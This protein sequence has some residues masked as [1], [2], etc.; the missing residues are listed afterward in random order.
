[1]NRNI[2]NIFGKKFGKLLVVKLTNER[3]RGYVI[4]KCKCDC[5]NISFVRSVDLL[6]GNVKSCGC[7][8]KEIGKKMIKTNR[9][10]THGHTRNRTATKIYMVWK[11]MK[12]R[13]LNSNN[14]NFKYYGGRGITICERWMKF[15]NFLADM[16]EQPKG[17]TI[18]RID[19]DGNYEPSNC[20]WA[21][22]KEQMQNSRRWGYA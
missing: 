2:K 4:W 13:C 18:E 17:L 10:K 6:S 12:Q 22:Q 5:G 9:R 11:T 15:E 20:R 8:R 3:R 7:W 21:T 1:M 16:G 19:N 14:K